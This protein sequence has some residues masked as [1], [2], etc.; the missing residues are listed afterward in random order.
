M[1]ILIIRSVSTAS[2]YNTWHP[3]V[4]G[5]IFTDFPTKSI[6]GGKF[7]KVP[8]IVG[9]VNPLASRAVSHN[10]IVP[11]RMRH[12]QAGTIP[13]LLCRI[14]SP[15]LPPPQPRNLSL[16]VL[17]CSCILMSLIPIYHLRLAIPFRRLCL[18]PRSSIP[19]SH[20]G[21]RATL[22]STLTT[23]LKRRRLN[24]LLSSF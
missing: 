23:S 22:C 6:L 7:A 20:W 9:Y 11:Q 2:G 21:L 19:N 5:K 10:F 14:F 13:L 15:L 24:S 1:L 17:S 3:V 12:F 18:A 8:L 16:S 4:D